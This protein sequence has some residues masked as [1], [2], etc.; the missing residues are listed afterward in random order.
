VDGRTVEGD[1]HEVLTAGHRLQEYKLTSFNKYE[2]NMLDW[3][4]VCSISSK[5]ER[6]EL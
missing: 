1:F 2:K 3:A 5:S 6:A 4:N